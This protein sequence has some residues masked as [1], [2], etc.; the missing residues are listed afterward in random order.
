MALSLAHWGDLRSH[1]ENRV[2][3]HTVAGVCKAL[4][5]GQACKANLDITIPARRNDHC[6]VPQDSIG[7]VIIDMELL[8][9]A[10]IGSWP[11]AVPLLASGVEGILW[12]LW[13]SPKLVVCDDD[14]SSN[15]CPIMV[16]SRD[17]IWAP[18]VFLF[19]VPLQRWHA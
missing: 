16:C 18:D 8:H 14:C 10:V 1:Y 2:R 11:G 15:I 3:V 17:T 6:R 4:Q 19:V 5:D 7:R 9:S 12:D 13:G